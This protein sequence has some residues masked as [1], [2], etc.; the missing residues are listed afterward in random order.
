MVKFYTQKFIVKDLTIRNEQDL[1][2]AMSSYE[3]VHYDLV[4]EFPDQLFAKPPTLKPLLEYYQEQAVDSVTNYFN[5]H[6]I[7]TDWV[8]TD[9]HNSKKKHAE[10][11]ETACTYWKCASLQELIDLGYVLSCSKNIKEGR[12]FL[13]KSQPFKKGE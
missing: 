11:V 10:H 4:G 9:N 13:F 7:Y 8:Q 1:W 3:D 2:K 6:E 5:M 12:F